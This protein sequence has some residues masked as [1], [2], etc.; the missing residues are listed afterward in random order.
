MKEGSKGQVFRK[1]FLLTVV[2]L[3]AGV[4]YKVAYMREA[5]YDAMLA[6]FQISNTQLGEISS[7][8][9]TV[10]LICYVPGGI[11]AD[12][13]HYKYLLCSSFIGT[14]VLT[15]WCA[16]MPGY[17]TVKLIFALM[18]IFTILTYWSAFVKTVRALGDDSEQGRL[19]G[20]AEGI[21]GVS[22]IVAS[23]IVMALIEAAANG[24]LGMRYM[25][26]FYGIIYMAVGVITFVLLPKP[27][28]RTEET[29]KEAFS[30]KEFVEAL[31]CK[32]TWIVCAI[33]F[34]WYVAYS[35]TSYSIPYLTNV[36]GVSS[37]LISSV[38]IIRAYAIG[39]LAAPF[40]GFTA[41]KIKS[42]SR[43]LAYFAIAG[44]VIIVV[45]LAIPTKSSWITIAVVITLLF[46]F[47]IFCARGIYFSPMAEVG[48]PFALTG[49][50]SGI[51]SIIGYS[52]DM[53]IYNI[54]G[55]WLDQYPGAKGYRYIFILTAVSM[56]AA[57]VVCWFAYR[58]GKKIKAE[59]KTE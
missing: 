45:L 11:L 15:L 9:G 22:G 7:L 18:G 4:I 32:G 17:G 35:A 6:G 43:A 5:F 19:F 24:V 28:K 54:M 13:I 52:P 40:A 41:D 10:A 27:E 50:A 51:I 16:T 46:S 36:F 14:G 59:K 55:K 53:F 44:L 57:F 47:V 2:A 33:V 3:G 58:Y 42:C 31:K 38:S 37:V 48:I 25:L 56:A 26:I 29:I 23:F 34:F 1:Y 30:L 8:Y 39:I 49:A 20:L 12:K 21:R